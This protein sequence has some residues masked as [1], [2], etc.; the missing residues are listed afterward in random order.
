MLDGAAL[1]AMPGQA[2][3]VLDVRG[4]VA[5]GQLADD[6]GVG[7]GLDPVRVSGANGAAGAVVDVDVAVV[8]PVDHALTRGDRHRPVDGVRSSAPFARRQARAAS[9][10]AARTS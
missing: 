1:H 7:L 2:V 4:D 9:L 10:S 5:C 3:G 6:A 8:A